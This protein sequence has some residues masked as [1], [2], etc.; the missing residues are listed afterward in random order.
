MEKFVLLTR[1]ERENEVLASKLASAG[2]TVVIKPML[3]IESFHSKTEFLSNLN[4]FDA[5]IFVSKNSVRHAMPLINEQSIDHLLNKN[6]LAIGR[7]TANELSKYGVSAEFPADSDTE[8]LLELEALKNVRSHR[9]LIIRGEGGRN[10]LERTLV[11]RGAYVSLSEVYRRKALSY[12]DLEA[13]PCG[14]V[15][16]STSVDS[17]ESLLLSLPVSREAYNLV[18]PSKRIEAIAKKLGFARVTN[19]GGASDEELYDAI[20]SFSGLSSDVRKSPLEQ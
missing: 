8:S 13:M 10:L 2:W 3:K 14:S 18:V 4:V 11:Q 6:W 1:P 19:S 15:L 7:G 17:L 5:L 20:M 12:S 16:T 9:V